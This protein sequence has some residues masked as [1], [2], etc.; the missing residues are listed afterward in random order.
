MKTLTPILFILLVLVLG[1][2]MGNV[3]KRSSTNFDPYT[4][5]LNDLLSPEMS[6]TLVKF[7][8]SGTRDTLG[9][10]KDAKEAKAFTYMQ[11]GGGIG[12]QL[13]GALVNF[14]SSAA[15]NADLSKTA[16]EINTTIEKNSNG[17]SLTAENGKVIGWTHGSIMC[18]VKSGAGTKP[19]SNFKEAAPF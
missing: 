3:L 9:D 5:S 12:V 7:K 2:G 10:Y 6:G 1:C 19:A 15:A 13:D 17:L 4:G 18:L 8:L 11:E 14:N 16:A